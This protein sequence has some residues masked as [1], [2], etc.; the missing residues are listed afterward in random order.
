MNFPYKV[1]DHNYFIPVDGM[2]CMDHQRRESLMLQSFSLG[3]KTNK[4][5]FVSLT[6]ELRLVFTNRIIDRD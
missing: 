2:G 1:G 4:Q 5:S 6:R 3:P